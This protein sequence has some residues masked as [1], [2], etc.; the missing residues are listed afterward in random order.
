MKHGS[1]FVDYLEHNRKAIKDQKQTTME[2][3][4]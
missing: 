1:R 2:V 4:K 3:S